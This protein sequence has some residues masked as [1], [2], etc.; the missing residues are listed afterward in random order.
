MEEMTG[1]M[2]VG[3]AGAEGVGADA[4]AGVGAGAGVEASPLEVAYQ[5][6]GAGGEGGQLA[7]FSLQPAR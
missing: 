7:L 6:R 3:V 4:D 1:S 5:P 2:E